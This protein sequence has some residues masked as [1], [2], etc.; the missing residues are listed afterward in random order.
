M[1]AGIRPR[2][3]GWVFDG[4]AS[5]ASPEE[6]GCDPST[7]CGPATDHDRLDSFVWLSNQSCVVDD[8]VSVYESTCPG[9]AIAPKKRLSPGDALSS[10]RPSKDSKE[11][12]LSHMRARRRARPRRC[13]GVVPESEWRVVRP[14]PAGSTGEPV[15][16]TTPARDASP[17]TI[18][19][20]SETR[21]RTMRRPARTP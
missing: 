5:C 16:A 12:R 13:L 20:G 19:I 7:P 6:N 8:V 15:A 1:P 11:A 10:A 18:G 4:M 21:G 14:P 3:D 2:A 9:A 17:V